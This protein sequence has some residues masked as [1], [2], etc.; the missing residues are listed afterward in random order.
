M[1]TPAYPVC[2]GY[3]TT[4]VMTKN[5]F[6][7]LS[8][9]LLAFAG[10]YFFRKAN[11]LSP[12]IQQLSL[13]QILSIKELHLAKHTYQDIFFLH[14]KNQSHR[15][16]RAIV[17]VPVTVTAYLNLKE[18]ELVRENDSIRV[19][20][21]PHAHLNEPNY[22]VDKMIIRET[23]SWQ[24]HLG[25]DLYPLVGNY[26]KERIAQRLDTLRQ[27]ALAHHILVQAET[28]GKEYIEG[29]L[30]ATNQ[31][32]IRVVFMEAQPENKGKK[33]SKSVAS[34]KVL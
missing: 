17:Q 31:S 3:S 18:I 23:R 25:K 7:F 10:G 8:V 15:P 13:E 30:K 16:I 12:T 9:A 20:V 32:H 34:A 22:Q 21:L 5:I 26:I 28:E 1:T 27:T 33:P 29:L 4:R 11:R 24:F 2:R 6:I 14:K 19:I